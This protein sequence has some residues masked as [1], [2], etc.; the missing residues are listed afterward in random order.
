MEIRTIERLPHIV[1]VLGC[2]LLTSCAIGQAR[3]PSPNPGPIAGEGAIQ[4]EALLEQIRILAS[5]EMEG[6]TSGMPGGARAADH[7]AQKFRKIGLIPL[8]DQGGYLQAFEV[9]T[10]I[11]LGA[12]NRLSLESGGERKA[13][14]AGVVFNPFGFSDEGSLS[15]EVVFAGYGITAPGLKYDDYAGLDV[16]DK[17]VLVMTHEPQEKNEEGPFRKPEAFPYTEI[18]Y[19][20]INAREHG[21]KGIIVVTD[22]NNHEREELFAIRGTSGASAGIIAINVLR[23]VAEAILSPT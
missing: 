22:P 10:G 14:E 5:P 15:G 3:N 6:R 1:F 20:V 4:A 8:G 2:I 13:Y 16:K 12:E 9:T 7:I 21:A 19:K 17:I 23:E 11:R 18:R